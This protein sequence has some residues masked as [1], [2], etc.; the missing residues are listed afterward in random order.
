M[1]KNWRHIRTILHFLKPNVR[2]KKKLKSQ[3]MYNAITSAYISGLGR[4][5]SLYRV[6]HQQQKQYFNLK[7]YFP[8][9]KLKFFTSKNLKRFQQDWKV[10]LY[11][12]NFFYNTYLLYLDE[13]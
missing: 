9:A 5:K 10:W 6:G 2:L 4:S 1:G 3:D 8:L 7:K 13:G 12:K 11:I